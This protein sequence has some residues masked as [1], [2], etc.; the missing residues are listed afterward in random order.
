MTGTPQIIGNK[1]RYTLASNP[2]TFPKAR[3]DYGWSF[4]DTDTIQGTY[5]DF[6]NIT[7]W[8]QKAQLQTVAPQ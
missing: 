1:V 4:D 7:V 5:S 6:E 8:P 3:Q 2:G